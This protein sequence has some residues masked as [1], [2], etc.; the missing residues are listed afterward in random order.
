MTVSPEGSVTEIVIQPRISK[1]K[2]APTFTHFPGVLL[3][4]HRRNI[5]LDRTG[6]DTLGEWYSQGNDLVRYIHRAELTIIVIEST[7]RPRAASGFLR[8]AGLAEMTRIT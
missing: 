3:S 7:S 5:R 2:I 1:E 6:S 4:N 8:D